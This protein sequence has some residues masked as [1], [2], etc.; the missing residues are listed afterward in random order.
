MYSSQ[1]FIVKYMETS[2]CNFWTSL[3]IIMLEIMFVKMCQDNS[4]C[5]DFNFSIRKIS[6]GNS[7]G[8]H[9]GPKN[10]TLM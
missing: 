10:R 3:F 4:S 8:P 2:I 1:G 5:G 6:S 9:G 7:S